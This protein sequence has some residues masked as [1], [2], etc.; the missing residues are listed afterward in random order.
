MQ[1][2]NLIHVTIGDFKEFLGLGPVL[3]GLETFQADEKFQNPLLLNRSTVCGAR[4]GQNFLLGLLIGS[5][6]KSFQN[7]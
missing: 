2:A 4:T 1:K 7:Y 3:K 6:M 5:C